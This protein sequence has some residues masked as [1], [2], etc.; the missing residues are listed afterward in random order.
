MAAEVETVTQHSDRVRSISLRPRHRR[1]FPPFVPGD[2]VQLQHETGL[3][4]DYS[5]ISAPDDA[6]HY[7]IAI[8]REPS[9][10]GGSVLFHDELRRGDTVYVSYPRP[11]I[12]I[13]PDAASHV[14]VAGGIGATAVLGLL[15]ALPSAHRS[16]MH[17]AVRR[18]EDA[19]FLES[20]ARHGVEVHVHVSA[21]GSRLDVDR[22]IKEAP[23]DATVYACGPERL[24][25]AVERAGAGRREGSV[26]VERFVTAPSPDE[27]QGDAF[28]AKLLGAGKTVDV[29]EGESLLRALRRSGV[30]VDFSCESGTCGS[31]VIEFARGDVQHRDV[32]LSEAERRSGFLATCVSR[33]A[34][35]IELLI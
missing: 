25:D 30:V 17:Y 18:P 32:C 15:P 24:L 9:G 29:G 11:G 2:H 6:S 22:V 28:T 23:T 20:F 26:R 1:G 21:Q 14:F 33:G 13:D 5:L 31:C 19:V 35:E 8:Q 12:R 16:V 3:R 34:G 10:R 4:R 27:R 7:E